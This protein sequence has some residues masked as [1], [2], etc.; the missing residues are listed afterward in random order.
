MEWTRPSDGHGRR[1]LLLTD[2]TGEL[3]YAQF[4]CV[5]VWVRKRYAFLVKT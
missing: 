2:V 1:G 5:A 3:T 4:R